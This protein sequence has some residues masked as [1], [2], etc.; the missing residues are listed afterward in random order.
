M[1]ADHQSEHG[2]PQKKLLDPEKNVINVSLQRPIKN[3]VFIGKLILKKFGDLEIHSLGKASES[4]I[5]IA[6]S[7]QRKEF[8]QIVKIESYVTEL[9]DRR[10]DSGTRQELAFR[11][12]MKKSAK[13][14]ELTKDLK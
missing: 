1:S 5:R 3:Y 6:E 7:L 12:V 8:A 13:F 9:T 4:V 11:V 14:D 2:I 10:N